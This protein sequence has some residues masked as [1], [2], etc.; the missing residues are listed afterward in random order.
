MIY[1]STA[2]THRIPDHVRRRL[3]HAYRT[4][5]P[6]VSIAARFRV[7]TATVQKA[8]IE[9]GIPSRTRLGLNRE[10]CNRRGNGY[11][12]ADDGWKLEAHIVYGPLWRD[13]FKLLGIER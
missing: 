7:S 12:V 13:A 3:A 9:A 1:E 10:Q 6:V 2:T 5:E 11:D 8:R 4:D